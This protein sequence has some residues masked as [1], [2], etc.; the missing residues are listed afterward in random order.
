MVFFTASEKMQRSV[1]DGLHGKKIH[2][3]GTAITLEMQHVEKE[4]HRITLHWLPPTYSA[5]AV[6]AVVEEITGD[7]RVEVFKLRNQEGK[8]GARYNP[9]R[10][11]PHYAS[12]EVPGHNYGI[13]F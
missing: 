6:K 3:P 8:W 5:E 9:T 1:Y 13:Q 11:I 12:I 10:T 4:K 2:V 7:G